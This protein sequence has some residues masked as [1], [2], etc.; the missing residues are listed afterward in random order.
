MSAAAPGAQARRGL[1]ALHAGTLLLGGTALFPKLISLPADQIV[2]LRSVV[3]AL[4]LLAFARLSGVSLKVARRA[5]AWMVALVGV[6]MAT[7]WVALFYCIQMTTVAVALVCLFTFPVLV[8]FLEPGFH[9][10]RVQRGDLAMARLVAA[11]V[12]VMIPDVSLADARTLGV[13]LGLGSALAYALRN[14]LYRRYLHAYPSTAMMF[15]QVLIAAILTLP[16]LRDGVDLARDWR[17]LYLIGLGVVFTALPHTLFAYS[18]RYLRAVT[19]S[20]IT[21][22]QPVYGTLLAI[23]VL[24]EW[25][26]PETVLGGALI[27]AAG[28][29][30]SVRRAR[31]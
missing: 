6:L 17:W 18:L 8:V 29:Y 16:A 11:G 28:V 24:A 1:F 3:A 7:H 27:L 15:Y 4:A 5:D 19:V 30:E 9:G 20:L 23:A 13:G 10:E 12:Y 2:A 26:H 25:P 21:S 22:L 14:V 31:R